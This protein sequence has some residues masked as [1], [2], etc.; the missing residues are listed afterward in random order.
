[1]RPTVHIGRFIRIWYA[2]Q[3]IYISSVAKF[4]ARK[5]GYWVSNDSSHDPND[6]HPLQDPNSPL[7]RIRLASEWE[8]S[9]QKRPIQLID[10]PALTA[11]LKSLAHQRSVSVI[12]LFY[13]YYQGMCSD[14]LS[15]YFP[16]KPALG[17]AR[18][19]PT[20]NIHSWLYWKNAGPLHSPI[21]LFPWLQWTETLSRSPFFS[22]LIIFKH[23]KPGCPDT[24]ALTL[25]LDQF[26]S[27]LCDNAKMQ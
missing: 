8:A 21:R 15:Q 1:M 19:L 2:L 10:D 9:K 25:Y 16:L 17:L 26:F 5:I 12:S 11:P 4:E 20:L 22:K 24:Y 13:R 6:S 3:W 27:S 18:D 14:K 7:S 23:S